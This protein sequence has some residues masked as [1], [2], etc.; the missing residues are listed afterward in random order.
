M[1]SFE[2]KPVNSKIVLVS[3]K[4]AAK[5]N[6]T[7]NKKITPVN[8]RSLNMSSVNRKLLKDRKASKSIPKEQNYL[9]IV[10]FVKKFIEIL[11][12]RT[13]KTK[14]KRMQSYQESILCDLSFFG[15][16]IT[17][18]DKA[19]LNN[20]IYRIYVFLKIFHSFQ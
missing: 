19:T 10:F 20:P 14:L 12:S 18:N 8:N 7:L 15:N 17:K 4:I 9:W 1:A 6:P 2:K 13:I 16:E 5:E 3:K 11:K